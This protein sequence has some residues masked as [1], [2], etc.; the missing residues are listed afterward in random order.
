MSQLEKNQISNDNPALD[1]DDDDLRMDGVSGG[2]IIFFLVSMAVISVV[3][4]VGMF[5]Y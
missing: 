5:F 3:A 2:L 1:Q 4:I